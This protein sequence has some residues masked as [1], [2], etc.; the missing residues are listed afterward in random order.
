M[1]ISVAVKWLSDR[2]IALVF[3]RDQT[4]SLPWSLK[5]CIALSLAEGLRYLHSQSLVHLDIKPD[6]VVIRDNWTCF[7]I[8]FQFAQWISDSPQQ[9]I[10]TWCYMAPELMGFEDSPRHPVTFMLLYH[11]LTQEAAWEK[12]SSSKIWYALPSC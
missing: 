10:G 3:I 6:N 11:L 7:W 12:L 2:F 5:L 9:E 1:P 4:Q 8:E